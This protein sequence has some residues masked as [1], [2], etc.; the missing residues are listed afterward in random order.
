MAHNSPFLSHQL[1]L[2]QNQAGVNRPSRPA[3]A[4]LLSG[5]AIGNL[6]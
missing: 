3:N 1:C 4:T 6:F 5:I 2:S